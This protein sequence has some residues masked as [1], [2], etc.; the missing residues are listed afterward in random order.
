MGA[1]EWGG[2]RREVASHLEGTNL[3]LLSLAY[4]DGMLPLCLPA[5]LIPCLLVGLGLHAIPIAVGAA[6]LPPGWPHSQGGV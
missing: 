4:P 2:A 6:V 1:R 5:G 3:G